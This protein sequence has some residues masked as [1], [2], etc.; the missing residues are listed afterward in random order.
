MEKAGEKMKNYEMNK[1]D[2]AKNIREVLQNA[3]EKYGSRDVVVEKL[4][5]KP[6][7]ISYGKF[8]GGISALGNAFAH[9]GLLEGKIAVLGETSAKWLMT[10]FATVC[11]NGVIVPVDKEL[12]PDE[13][14]H[15][16]RDSGAA[17]IV[18]SDTYADVMQQIRSDV[19]GVRYFI[20][21]QAQEDKDGFLSYDQI[22]EKGRNQEDI[23]SGIEIDNEKLA[24][25]LYTSGTTGRS[26]GV[27]LSH[28][29]IVRASDGAVYYLD[30]GK[31]CMSCLPVHHSFEFAHGI[32][33]MLQ[34]GTT[35]CI[36]DSLRYFADNLK[37]YRPE[38]MFVV[39][40]FVEMLY[41]KFAAEYK[42]NG[43]DLRELIDKSN[44]LREQG[45]D[46]RNEF[47][48]GVKEAFGGRMQLVIC[49]GAPLSAQRM[50]D[51][52]DM[53]ILLL[54][55]YGITECAPLIS[56]NRNRYYKDGSVGL[57]IP[58]L[59]IE[60]RSKDEDGEGEIWVKGD[61]V[62]LGYFGNPEATEK[63]LVDGWFNTEDIGHID[64]DDFIFITGRKKNLIILT[65]GKNVYPEEIEDYI[66]KIPYVKEAVVYAPMESGQDE[67]KLCAAVFLDEN[68]A[69]Q[70]TKEELLK[71]LQKDMNEIN[72]QLPIY[73]QVQ[74]FTIRDSE[75]EKTTKKSIKRF[76]SVPQK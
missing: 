42:K 72:R 17:C 31:V 1:I 19:E 45:T 2:G 32:M 4:E 29:N 61:N 76:A 69:A 48:A 8:M 39:P 52:R 50:K 68:F 11:G 60:V 63:V 36:N 27:M 53:G 9:M 16:L 65:N 73:K 34:N 15:I 22:V 35:I 23:Y 49:G 20:D 30:M 64:D 10:Y 26:K 44:A 25:L 41:G 43:V 24:A 13:M 6:K 28:K 46:K 7:G 3:K 62:M 59:D 71:L 54:N 55:G 66:L 51:F 75:F 74:D 12:P 5:G 70:R 58:S 38:I 56:V 18:F 67:T 47:F 14:A 21:M 57:C 33:T 37:L 40:A